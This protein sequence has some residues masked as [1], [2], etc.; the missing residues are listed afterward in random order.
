MQL[1]G[2]HT[3]QGNPQEIAKEQPWLLRA[4]RLGLQRGGGEQ[5][6]QVCIVIV[7]MPPGKAGQRAILAAQTLSSQPPQPGRKGKT[8]MG[9][10][11]PAR[12]P[13][14]G[15]PLRPYPKKS[16]RQATCLDLQTSLPLP[17]PSPTAEAC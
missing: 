4:R 3:G 15:P 10:C 2:R 7:K 6:G 1:G 16:Q 5:S 11:L 8:K 17:A 14:G 9:S 13:R 12:M